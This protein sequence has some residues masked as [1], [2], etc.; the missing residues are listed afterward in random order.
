MIQVN[1][2]SVSRIHSRLRK[3]NQSFQIHDNI[4]IGLISHSLLGFL[5]TMVLT[6]THVTISV[7]PID[8][9]TCPNVG[10]TS[11]NRALR[12]YPGVC[13]SYIVTNLHLLV[14]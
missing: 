7:I 12:L 13:F 11:I 9:F 2:F 3:N 10:Q 8:W 6:L 14:I 4:K 1:R 5:N